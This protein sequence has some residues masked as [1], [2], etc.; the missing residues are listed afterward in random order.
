LVKDGDIRAALRTDEVVDEKEEL[1]ND[2]D[3]IHVPESSCLSN[4]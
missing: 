4:L 1:P 3:A 2:W